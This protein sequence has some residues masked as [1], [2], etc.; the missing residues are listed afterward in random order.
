MLSCPYCS[1]LQPKVLL[2]CCMFALHIRED[3]CCST[4]LHRLPIDDGL[5]CLKGRARAGMLLA[6]LTCGGRVSVCL[7]L[8]LVNPI[9]GLNCPLQFV[10]V[11]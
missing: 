10:G 5:G 6:L 1:L 2:R 8:C 7:Q 4:L 9:L 3:N 11:S